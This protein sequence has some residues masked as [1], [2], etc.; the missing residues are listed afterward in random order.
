[1]PLDMTSTDTYDTP[2]STPDPYATSSSSPTT[3]YGLPSYIDLS[4]LPSGLPILG[5][6]TGYTAGTKAATIHS[7]NASMSKAAHRPLTDSEQAALAY[8]AAKNFSINSWAP[9]LSIGA[10]VYRTYATR[11]VFR[12]PFYGRLISTAPSAEGEAPKGFWDGEKMRVG[13]REILQGLSSQAKANILHVL[14]GSAYCLISLFVGGMAVG[15]YA[16]TVSGVGQ[17][18]DPRLQDL[19][20]RIKEAT[21]REQRQEMGKAAEA[22]KQTEARRMPNV[23]RE[24]D[25]GR[26]R[27]GGAAEVDD[28]SPTGGAGMMMDIGIDDEQERLSGAADMGGVLSDGQMRTAEAKARPRPNRSPTSNRTPTYQMETVERQP[29]DFASDFDD[30][31][32]TGGSGAMDGGADG[33]GGSV[34]E[35]I[36]QQSASEPSSVPT[37]ST[38]SRR[39]EEGSGDSFS[40]SSSDEERS[41]AKSGAQREFDERVEK[42]RR[43]G[44]FGSAGGRRW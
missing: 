11:A 41:F 13:G 44:D 36:R 20:R 37:T 35:R 12:W 28:A 38:G 26:G 34:W 7:L 19:N 43:G 33:S 32:P 31:S 9:T 4:A 8:H 15:T 40:F 10:G 27:R 16:A 42:E 2:E 24:R 30:A 29:K 14:R 25:Q 18:R 1:M 23:P 5:P 6:L 17:L 21:V 3:N 22:A 39:R